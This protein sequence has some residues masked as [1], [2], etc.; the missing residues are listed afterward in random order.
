ML[1]NISFKRIISSGK[2]IP[3]IDGLRFIAISSVIFYH[4]IAFII[5]KTSLDYS[6][7]SN[8]FLINIFFNGDY[9]VPLFL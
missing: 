1:K 2:F 9:G 4:I 8:N 3:E 6:E 7:V 5:D